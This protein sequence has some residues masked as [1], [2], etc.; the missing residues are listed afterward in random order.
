MSK[1]EF[2]GEIYT[3]TFSD[4]P[5]DIY[6]SVLEDDSFSKYSSDSNNANIRTKIRQKAVVIDSDTYRE[7]HGAGQ[8]TSASTEE[9]TK[10]NISRKLEDFT[11]V[12]SVTTECKNPQSVSEI[13][14]LIPGCSN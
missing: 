4:F 13:T 5:S 6:T 12:S 2:F 7:I 8:C 3:G 11:G 1:E 14:E 10:D 9:R